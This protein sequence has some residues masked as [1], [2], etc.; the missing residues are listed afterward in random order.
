MGTGRVRNRSEEGKQNPKMSC[1]DLKIPNTTMRRATEDT[2]ASSTWDHMITP[3]HLW[4]SLSLVAMKRCASFWYCTSF[5]GLGVGESGAGNYHEEE[6]E[7][8]R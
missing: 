3:G 2:K 1:Y 4:M 8:G 6:R 7:E 5:S